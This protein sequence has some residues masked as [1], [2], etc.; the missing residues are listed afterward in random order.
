M[1]G[2]SAAARAR[3]GNVGLGQRLPW[4]HHARP[5]STMQRPSCQCWHRSDTPATASFTPA[6]C[7]S[8]CARTEQDLVCWSSN[9]LARIDARFTSSHIAFATGAAGRTSQVPVAGEALRALRAD[10][11]RHCILYDCIQSIHDQQ[12]TGVHYPMHADKHLAADSHLLL[13]TP[14]DQRLWWGG[15]PATAAAAPH[16][17]ASAH[18]DHR[19]AHFCR[20]AR[21]GCMGNRAGV[22]HKARYPVVRGSSH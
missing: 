22:C 18:E 8:V 1:R 11:G 7:S 20:C 21:R 9:T 12:H 15:L 3:K 5:A 17:V 10:Q 2:W 19:G 4:R 16:L 6:L 13:P 14:L